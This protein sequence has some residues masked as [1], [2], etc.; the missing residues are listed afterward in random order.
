ME[1]VDTKK[2]RFG[3]TDLMLAFVTLMWGLNY[4]IVKVSLKEIGPLLFNTLR[5]AIGSAVC[6]I[7]LLTKE[8]EIK[9]SK[10]QLIYLV[11]TG[12]IAH[13]INQISFIYGVAK[14]T[15]GA[16]SI[17]LAST[18]VC[19]VLLARLLKLEKVTMKTY[20]GII[21]SFMGV[22]L[23]VMG[24]GNPFAGGIEAAKGNILIVVATVFWSIYTIMIR[25]YFKD[26]STIKVT[27]YSLSFTTIFFLILSA[28]QVLQSEWASFSTAAWGGVFF[29]GVF[30]LGISYILWNTGVHRVGPT[31][32]AIYANLPPFISVLFGWLILG[33]TISPMQIVGGFIIM[34]GLVYSK[35]R[36]IEEYP[37]IMKDQACKSS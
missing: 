18:P 12:I 11:F 37:P 22:T 35:N 26:L 15:A 2:N 25:M 5:F 28:K 7:I 24:S 6:W 27:T 32:T 20:I 10:K 21:I 4:V 9:I 23:V 30:V 31:R 14:T 8:R 13:G 36:K 19:V 16:T 3:S 33:E 1:V 34:M 29:S 17:I